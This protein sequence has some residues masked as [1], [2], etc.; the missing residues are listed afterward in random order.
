MESIFFEISIVLIVS[1]TC[2]A[3]AKLLRQPMIPAY[4]LAGVLLGP[5]FFHVIES[6]EL[7]KTLSTFGI[8]FLLFLVGIELDLRKFIKTGKVALIIGAGQMIFAIASGFVVIKLLGFS[9]TSAW[10]LAI[11]IGFSST[12]LIMKILGE[13]KELETLHGRLVI[14]LMLTQDFIAVMFLI[15]FEVFA[16][17][18]GDLLPQVGFTIV[19]GFFLISL[20]L[21]LSKYV[22]K[23]IFSYFARTAELL[24]LGSIC[25]CLIFAM[26]SIMLGFSVEVGALLAGVSLSFLP[27]HIEIAHRIKSLRDFFLPI[28][29]AV[30]GGQLI[31]DSGLGV[32]I[33]TIVLS[34]LVLVLSPIVVIGLMLWLGY[35]ARTSFLVG[36]SIGQVSEFSF[37]VVTLGFTS[38][39][40]E[41][42]IVSLVALIGLVTMTLST[43]MI[44]YSNQ[45]YHIFK[46]LVRKF[47]R[48]GVA[49]R[50][51]S[52]PKELSKH[53]VL[54]GYD[55]MGYKIRDIIDDL[56]KE[57]VIVD[58]NPEV[59]KK[60]KQEGIH[61]IYG[62]MCEEEILDKAQINTADIVISTAPD[63]KA[64]VSLLDYI[65]KSKKKQ[66][67]IVTAFNTDDALEFYRHGASYVL[68]PK[69]ISVDYLSELINSRLST[70]RADHIKELRRLKSIALQA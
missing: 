17:G 54:F 4:I 60:L 28:F 5:S 69:N 45:I 41:R 12:I 27:Y 36:V 20:A 19:K 48:Q 33:P 24:F 68:V 59:I 43:Y 16:S 58:F 53:I 23:Y 31:F 64:T 40:I 25:W 21:I 44:E 10:F 34:F 49:A 6:E 66:A 56:G 30:L 42:D 32:A 37:I 22:L 55:T 29:F 65:K 38:G 62:N 2:A 18:G 13:R 39:V 3:I 15:F 61:H 70:K 67:V 50:L 51:D 9:N 26:L 1:T 52:V 57:F 14:G 35:R 7:L 46:P 63:A 8:A 11:A 47:E